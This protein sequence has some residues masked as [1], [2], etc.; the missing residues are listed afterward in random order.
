MM[1]LFGN[2]HSAYKQL[3]SAHL[4]GQ[5]D[6]AGE[7]SLEKHLAS[8]ET[9]AVEIREQSAVRNLLRA[10]PLVNVP[11]SFALPYAPTRAVDPEPGLAARAGS[12]LRGMQVATATAAV[13]LVALIGVSIVG[14]GAT[15]TSQTLSAA[16]DSEVA[17]TAPAAATDSTIGKSTEPTPNAILEFAAADGQES[18]PSMGFRLPRSFGTASGPALSVVSLGSRAPPRPPGRASALRASPLP[19]FPQA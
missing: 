10:Q 1:R 3:V 18:A 5:L 15:D 19:T 12:L 6:A 7:A 2:R 13:V 17:L 8:C 9:C 4:D 14:P 11:R 16:L